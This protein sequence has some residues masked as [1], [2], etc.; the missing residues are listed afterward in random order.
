[1]EGSYLTMNHR[2]LLPILAAAL[3]FLH[4][5][6]IIKPNEDKTAAVFSHADF[7]NILLIDAGHGGA[8][9]GAVAPDGTLE[10]NINLSI[11]IK[12][13]DLAH[14]LAVRTIMTRES[15]HLPYPESANSIREMKRWDQK[16]RLDI[17]NSS[18]NGVLISIHQNKYP[19]SR[20]YGPQVLYGKLGESEEFGNLCHQM[21][22]DHLSPDNR[23]VA[24]PAAEDIYLIK[25]AKCDSVLVECGFLSNTEELSKLCTDGYQ[26]KIAAILLTSYLNFY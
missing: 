21:L 6:G 5:T 15:E 8:D 23:R 9:G 2:K 26:T 17:I 10:S 1:M 24:T 22:N 20:P 3:L 12:L 16:R 25:N 14:F 13:H 11:A 4:I 19:D 18:E 7:G